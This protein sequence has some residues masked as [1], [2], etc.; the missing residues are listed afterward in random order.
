MLVDQTA[1]TM[2]Y[3]RL[4]LVSRRL[5]P[6]A[7]DKGGGTCGAGTCDLHEEHH[8]KVSLVCTVCDPGSGV[9]CRWSTAAGAGRETE[10]EGRNR[11]TAAISPHH[12]PYRSAGGRI[13]R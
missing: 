5:V 13:R 2:L 10:E 7:P 6:A 8:A 9:Q 4:A 11:D 3:T 1:G 12:H